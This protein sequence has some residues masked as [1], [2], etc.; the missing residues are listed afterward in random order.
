[1][2]ESE[3]K[4]DFRSEQGFYLRSSPGMKHSNLIFF[5]TFEVRI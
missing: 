5:W 4:K 1:M 3:I 2:N